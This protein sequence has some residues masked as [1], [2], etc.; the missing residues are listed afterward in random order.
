MPL[1]AEPAG[2]GAGWPQAPHPGG[3]PRHFSNLSRDK[4][5]L[6]SSNRGI[7]ALIPAWWQGRSP[8]MRGQ[9]QGT[10]PITCNASASPNTFLDL[11]IAPWTPSFPYS[12]SKKATQNHILQLLECLLTQGSQLL[13]AHPSRS[14]DCSHRTHKQKW[15]L[16]A[17]GLNSSPQTF[18]APRKQEGVRVTPGARQHCPRQVPAV[19]SLLI[20]CLTS[21]G[22]RSP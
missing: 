4:L 11:D 7:A 8:C 21:F 16:S 14:R 6:P 10:D 12:S 22:N 18:T 1:P 19:I 9:L 20:P 15:S 3:L 5:R 13:A 17:V 2:H